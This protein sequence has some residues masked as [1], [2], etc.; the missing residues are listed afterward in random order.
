MIIVADSGSTKTQW[1][2]LYSDYPDIITEGINP[3]YRNSKGIYEL[4]KTKFLNIEETVSKVFFFGAGCNN[5]EQI[6]IVMQGIQSLWSN[7]IIS[8]ESDLKAVC[9]A[10]SQQEEGI[11]CILGT[12]ANSCYFD[13]SNVA[14]NVS[15]LGYIL[16]DEGSGAFLGKQLINAIYK[17]RLNS[18]IKLSFEAEFKCDVNTVLNRV[19]KQPLANRY[20]ASFVPFIKANLDNS[21]IKHLVEEAFGLFIQN[22]V[23]QY[24]K[25]SS[26]PIHFVGSVAYYFSEILE[27]ELEK[28]G[29][30]AGKILQSPMEGLKK[31]YK[32]TLQ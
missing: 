23:L 24:D 17:G 26:L 19:Y 3:Y 2:F 11:C 16:G 27:Q 6:D 30:R 12:G 15:P 21:E 4:I 28:H 7:A 29:L 18:T 14:E 1:S 20:L 22:N 9:Y 10:T 32:K 13:G 8:V 31:Y 25:S 5:A